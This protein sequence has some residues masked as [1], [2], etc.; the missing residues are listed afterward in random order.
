VARYRCPRCDEESN[1]LSEP[2]LCRDIAR[3]L[4]RRERQVEAV[5]G[6]LDEYDSHPGGHAMAEAIVAKLSQMG[7]A[8]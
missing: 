5:L 2:H 1:T 8:D 6:I 3:R 7:V 4:A